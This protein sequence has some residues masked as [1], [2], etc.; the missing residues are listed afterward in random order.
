MEKQKVNI[1]E[2][3]KE[4]LN[5]RIVNSQKMIEVLKEEGLIGESLEKQLRLNTYDEK[6]IR[7]IYEQLTGIMN[8]NDV[9]DKSQEKCDKKFEQDISDLVIGKTKLSNDN[10]LNKE[11]EECQ[12]LVTEMSVLMENVKKQ[13]FPKKTTH[14]KELSPSLINSISTQSLKPMLKDSLDKLS[15]MKEEVYAEIAKAQSTVSFYVDLQ[16]LLNKLYNLI[17]Q[18]AQDE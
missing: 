5:E 16:F 13:F 7:G 3:A 10:S 17:E 15:K 1:T 2:Q 11:R 18:K 4:E 14:I 6:Y 8:E 9:L 12:K